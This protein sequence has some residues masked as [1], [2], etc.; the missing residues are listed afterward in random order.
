MITYSINKITI[1]VIKIHVKY[2]KYGY[3][4]IFN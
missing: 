4:K 2:C 3:I 1:E